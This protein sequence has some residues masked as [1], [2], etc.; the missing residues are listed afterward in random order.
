VRGR[1]A[2]QRCDGL[3]RAGLLHVAENRIEQHDREDRDGFVGKRGVALDEPERR[4]DCGGDE[5]QQHERVGELLDELA[6][7][8]HGLASGNSFRRAHDLCRASSSKPACVGADASSASATF[9]AV[10]PVLGQAC[11]SKENGNSDRAAYARSLRASP[12]AAAQSAAM[13]KKPEGPRLA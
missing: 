1:H 7:G 12:Q 8:R 3:L 9:G 10:R 4:G 13:I 6:P 5:E 2:L 11:S